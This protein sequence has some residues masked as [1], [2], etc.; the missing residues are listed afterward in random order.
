MFHYL[1]MGF[2]YDICNRI[3]CGA[4]TDASEVTVY[5]LDSDGDWL[6]WPHSYKNKRLETLQFQVSY[7][8]TP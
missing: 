4:E 6:N 5:V 1:L 2:H 7:F 3:I 8:G